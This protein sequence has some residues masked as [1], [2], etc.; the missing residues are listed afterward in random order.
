[1]RY[2][3]LLLT[4]AASFTVLALAGASAFPSSTTRVSVDSA[5]ARREPLV[6]PQNREVMV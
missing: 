2:K 5:G 4:V 1:M 3:L 6:R